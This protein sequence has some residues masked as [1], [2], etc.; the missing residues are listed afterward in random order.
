LALY[1]FKEIVAYKFYRNIGSL[2]AGVNHCID[3]GLAFASLI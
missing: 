2:N 3:D 1:G